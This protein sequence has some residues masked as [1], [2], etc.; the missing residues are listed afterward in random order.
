MVDEKK[1]G[2]EW[3]AIFHTSIGLKYRTKPRPRPHNALVAETTEC[4]NPILGIVPTAGKSLRG[5]GGHLRRCQIY[6][7]P[8]IPA[9]PASR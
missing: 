7:R 4:G 8:K 9:M 1:T 5:S 6:V 2:A 3:Q